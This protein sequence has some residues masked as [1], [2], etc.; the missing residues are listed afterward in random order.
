MR[1][2]SEENLSQGLRIVE[3]QLDSAVVQKNDALTL[4]RVLL[5]RA[6]LDDWRVLFR[7]YIITIDTLLRRIISRKQT[8]QGLNMCQDQ[9][10]SYLYANTQLRT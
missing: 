7:I 8:D 1:R 5:S 4:T 3:F 2:M 10:R 6:Q 9:G